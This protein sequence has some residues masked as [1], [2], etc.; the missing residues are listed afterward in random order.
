M[1]YLT[2]EG[3]GG[4]ME[5]GKNGWMERVYN[6]TEE[7]EKMMEVGCWRVEG[8]RGVVEVYRK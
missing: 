4:G 1:Y 2:K 8:K 6:S 3:G 5:E 7:E